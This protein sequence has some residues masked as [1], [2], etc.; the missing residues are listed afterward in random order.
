MA[1]PLFT[2]IAATM[3]REAPNLNVGTAVL[4]ELAAHAC[5]LI[6]AYLAAH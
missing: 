3:P 5:K 2:F 6:A 1:P 4:A